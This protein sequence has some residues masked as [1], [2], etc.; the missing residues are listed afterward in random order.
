MSTATILPLP[1][2]VFYDAN[3]A[4]LSGGW[5]YTYVPGGTT[6]KTTWEDAA[7]TT[8][9]DNPILLDANGSCLLYGSGAYQITVTDALGNQVP[10]YSGLTLDTLSPLTAFIASVTGDLMPAIPNI[11][12]LRTATSTTLPQS[13]C[14]VLGFATTADGGQDIFIIGPNADDNGGTVINDGSGRSWYRQTNSLMWS[15]LWFGAKLDGVTDDTTAWT[16]IL[17][18]ARLAGNPA[19]FHPGGQS[20]LTGNLVLDNDTLIGVGSFYAGPSGIT[21]DSMIIFHGNNAGITLLAA[22]SGGFTLEKIG[23]KGIPATYSAQGGFLLSDDLRTGLGEGWPTFRDVSFGAFTIG[24]MVGEKYQSGWMWNVYFYDCVE[25]GYEN[26]STDWY[27]HGI[28]CGSSSVIASFAQLVLGPAAPSSFSSGSHQFIG[29]AFFGADFTVVIRNSFGSSIRG[30]AIQNAQSSGVIIGD[31]TNGCGNNTIDGCTFS[32][33]NAAGGTRN[34]GNATGADITMNAGVRQNI[35]TG[36]FFAQN[37]AGNT[38]VGFSIA[39]AGFDT[40]NQISNNHFNMDNIVT[41]T[42]PSAPVAIT[43]PAS[44]ALSG[45]DQIMVTDNMASYGENGIYPVQFQPVNMTSLFAA[46]SVTG[47]TLSL[48]AGSAY[49]GGSVAVTLPDPVII[50]RT[51]TISGATGNSFSTATA[52]GLNNTNQ[53]CT[54][55]AASWISLLSDGAT[56]WVITGS[57]AVTLT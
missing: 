34:A 10:A 35:I 36:N 47:T 31:G 11:A 55:G 5:V 53:T 12:A 24:G 44:L 8:P 43:V 26:D 37:G 14:N 3:A 18:A 29:G 48:Q 7:E 30:A 2:A 4:P 28:S 1:R 46:V 56:G 20:I 49:L 9:N 32:G 50:G 39:L 51:M 38:A 25:I 45:G 13:Q 22:T 21:Q 19:I 52:N 33:N 15:V 17:L 27:H 6:P 57:N 41:P 23:F 42:M 16:N 40:G 54:F